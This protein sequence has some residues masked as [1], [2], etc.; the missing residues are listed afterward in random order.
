M[1]NNRKYSTLMHSLEQTWKLT[2]PL[3]REYRHP[4]SKH[5]LGGFQ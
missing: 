4:L 2:R 5:Y 3:P 1:K